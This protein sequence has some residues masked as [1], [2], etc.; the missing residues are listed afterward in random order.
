MAKGKKKSLILVDFLWKTSIILIRMDIVTGTVLDSPPALCRLGAGRYVV[1]VKQLR[2]ALREG[3][4][5]QV[6]LAQDADPKLTEDVAALCCSGHVPYAWVPSMADLGKACGI[7][8]GAAA[9][10]AIRS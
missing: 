5:A 2:K 9:A 10:A 7:S 1:G 3:R 8:V 6:Y 4:A